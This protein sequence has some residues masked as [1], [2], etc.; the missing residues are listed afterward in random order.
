MLNYRAILNENIQLKKE[1]FGLQKDAVLMKELRQEN[2]RLKKLLSFRE[3]LQLNTVAARIIAR[4]PNNW[5]RGVVINKGDRQ[6]VKTG[7]VVITELGLV[8][9]IMETSGSFSKIILINDTDNAVS[10]LIQRSREEGLISG[11]LIGGIAMRYLEKEA[12]VAQGDIVLTSGLTRNYPASILI[13]EVKEVKEEPQGLG[14]Y[15]VIK[16]AVDLRKIEEVL[17]IVE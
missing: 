8:G 6:G 10:A 16:P 15:A 17:V 3:Q 5:S 13:G 4:D 14:K 7:N 12:D 1:I 2:N 9:R 11:T